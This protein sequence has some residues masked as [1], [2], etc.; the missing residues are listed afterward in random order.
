VGQYNAQ[1]R[2]ALRD[3]RTDQPLLIA[4]GAGGYASMSA[5]ATNDLR[6]DWLV[7]FRPNPGT[8]LFAG[9]GSS[10]TEADAF[11]FQQVARVQDGFFVKLSYLFRL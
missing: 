1:E 2:D 4:D 6:V 7:S 5:T 8:V 9:Y 10:L 11:A 3:P